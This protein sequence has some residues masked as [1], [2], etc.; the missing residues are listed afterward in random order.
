MVLGNATIRSLSR[1]PDVIRRKESTRSP[2]NA[3][4]NTMRV[5]YF[6]WLHN[7]LAERNDRLYGVSN[8]KTREKQ[9]PVVMEGKYVSH[10]KV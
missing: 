3:P 6:I 8:E 7:A 1:T 10:L 5:C 9:F 2:H 4:L